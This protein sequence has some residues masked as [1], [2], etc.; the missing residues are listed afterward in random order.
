VERTRRE[1]LARLPI[2]PS[3]LVKIL[4]VKF[5]TVFSMSAKIN[6]TKELANLVN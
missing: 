1:F 2:N 3:T 4:V 5:L 6:V